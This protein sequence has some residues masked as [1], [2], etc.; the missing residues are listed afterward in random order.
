MSIPGP[1]DALFTPEQIKK[2]LVFAAYSPKLEKRVSYY[3]SSVQKGTVNYRRIV[4]WY[5]NERDFQTDSYVNRITKENLFNWITGTGYVI[6]LPPKPKTSQT[7]TEE[8]N[9]ALYQN[10]HKAGLA[11]MKKVVP[12]PMIV[13]ERLHPMDDN[14]PVVKEY[15][16][17]G[18]VVGMVF[19]NIKPGTSSF[20]RFLRKNNI[21]R[22]D[23]YRGGVTFMT[24]EGG[25]S[26]AW[27]EGYANGFTTYLR[28]RGIH[29]I[30]QLHVD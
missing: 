5:N 23:D 14:S 11:A 24:L 4:F 18:G 20:A 21:A 27:N 3:V 6:A 30:Y 29:A 7:F 1:I 13:Q 22:T 28:H 8:E 16:V 25:Q 19:V 2:G 15:Y 9:L 10:A 17:E 26:L 12:Q